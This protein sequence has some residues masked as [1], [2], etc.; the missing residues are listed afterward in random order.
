MSSISEFFRRKPER[1]A[2]RVPADWEKKLETLE[3][4]AENAPRAFQG[5]PLNRA[6]DL[7]LRVGDHERALGYYGRAIDALLGDGQREAARGVANKIIRVHPEA[8][9]TLC[10]LTW[11]DLAAGHQA[12]ALMHLRDYVSAA[13]RVEQ[14][15][16]AADQI[17]GMAG[18]TTDDEFLV[19]AADSLDRLGFADRSAR[20]REWASS[21]GG[22]EAI[23][24]PDRLSA[25]CLEAALGS[26]RRRS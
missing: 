4:E 5:T 25:A 15:L 13:A 19:A 26:N 16:L 21:A 14:E 23:R 18:A 10:T 12:T 3:A 22:P 6:G 1:P 11:L 2:T 17:Y 24:N 8:V 9:R 7:C 20:V